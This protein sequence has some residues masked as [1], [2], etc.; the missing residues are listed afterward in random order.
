[1]GC[2]E[3]QGYLFAKPMSARALL[4]WAMDDR[5]ESTAFSSSL[6]GNT[7]A[8]VDTPVQPRAGAAGAAGEAAAEDRADLGWPTL[9]QRRA[10]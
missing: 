10:A 6:F 5:S 2:D 7:E 3:M 9:V 1:M 4:L 8:F